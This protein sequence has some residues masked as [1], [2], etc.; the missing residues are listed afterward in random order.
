MIYQ[1]NGV[2]L[3]WSAR[4]SVLWQL[5]GGDGFVKAGVNYECSAGTQRVNLDVLTLIMSAVLGLKELISMYLRWPARACTHRPT[6][7]HWLVLH[8]RKTEEWGGV[9]VYDRGE[10]RGGSL[11]KASDSRP[12]DPSFKPSQE[13]KKNVCKIFRVK[14][15]V[16]TRC[17]C[18]R[19]T[20]YI[21]YI[22]THA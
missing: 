1:H 6:H 20:M 5:N 15:I 11:G 7:L 22:Y 8:W 13:H 3:V 21:I 2:V 4:V 19:S 14:N 10:G 9:C 17:R 18:A 16:L 12:K